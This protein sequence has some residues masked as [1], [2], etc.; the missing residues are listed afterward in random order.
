MDFIEAIKIMIQAF[1]KM[2]YI[3][4]GGGSIFLIIVL[5]FYIDNKFKLSNKIKNIIDDFII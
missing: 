5:F 2:V 1:F 3:L 4:T